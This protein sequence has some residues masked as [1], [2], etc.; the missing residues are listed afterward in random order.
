VVL[1]AVLAVTAGCGS[2]EAERVAEATATPR[3]AAGPFEWVSVDLG[4]QMP[5]AAALG[6]GFVGSTAEVNP[7]G[8]E[9]GWSA[10]MSR[11]LT[12]P[13]GVTWTEPDIPVLES[14]EMVSWQDGGPFG[15]IGYVMSATSQSMVPDLLFTPDGETWLRGRL[16]D[17]VLEQAEMGFGPETYAVGAAGVMAAL[18]FSG[19]QDAESLVLLT[20]DLRSWQE[21]EHPLPTSGDMG[22]EVRANPDGDYLLSE[23]VMS[24]MAGDSFDPV[25]IVGAVS[26]DGQTWQLV[27]STEQ[28]RIPGAGNGWSTGWSDG[29]AVVTDIVTEDAPAFEEPMGQPQIWLSTQDGTWS[30]VDMG[31]V[32]AS[33]LHGLYG[34]SLGLLVMGE[35]WAEQGPESGGENTSLVLTSDGQDWEA[36]NLRDTFGGGGAM[37]LVM[38]HTRLLLG[39]SG[40]NVPESAG[41]QLWI[42]TPT[43]R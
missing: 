15:A 35:D 6:D 27:T 28:Y 37:P 33:H 22:L 19:E 9:T 12:S 38:G 36:I 26:T 5:E 18:P 39:I 2:Q 29:F 43:E 17:E 21:V 25:P 10:L 13:D 4:V 16:P 34:S 3:G 8:D 11:V 14:D 20:E 30:A 24:K 7:D 31:A 23:P 1:A 32:P 42:G 40:P 41:T